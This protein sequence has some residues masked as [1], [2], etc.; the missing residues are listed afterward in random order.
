MKYL[1]LCSHSDEHKGAYLS[2]LGIEFIGSSALQ[3]VTGYLQIQ[4]IGLGMEMNDCVWVRQQNLSLLHEF[5]LIND[6]SV[7]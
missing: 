7:F 1:L 3:S 6:C 5:V 2:H 4:M